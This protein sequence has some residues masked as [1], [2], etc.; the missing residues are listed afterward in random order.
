MRRRAPSSAPSPASTRRAGVAEVAL[1]TPLRE[2][3]RH[4]GGGARR[5]RTLAFVLPG[6]SN[7]VIPASRLDT[8]LTYE[9]MT[10]IGSGLGSAGFVVFDDT[11]DPVAVAAGV[12][13]FLAVES[14]GQCT[15][16]KLGGLRI[17]EL[18]ERA[19][20]CD[21]TA[22]DGK[23]LATLLAG[24]ADSAR[25][26]LASQQRAVVGSLL[27]QHP[28]AF[29][30]HFAGSAAAR[31]PEP[32]AELSG[33]AGGRATIDEHQLAKQPDWTYGEH[34]SGKVPAARLGEHR[35]AAPLGAGPI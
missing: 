28:E 29:A 14:C 12:S 25:C 32:V 2:V 7:G 21:A 24:V 19:A 23:T 16:C 10:R 18:L 17:A 33:L 8:P 9:D 5:G 4:V 11:A 27:A 1:G 6:V 20:R 15:P 26:S 3:L 30:A 31:D 34:S 13:R 35:A 22:G